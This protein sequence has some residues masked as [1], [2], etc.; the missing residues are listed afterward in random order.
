MSKVGFVRTERHPLYA[1]FSWFPAISAAFDD[2]NLVSCAG[3]ARTLSLAQR[4]GW[5]TWCRPR[6]PDG[7]G[8]GERAPEGPGTGRGMA[9]GA[10]RIDGMDLLR[11]GGISRLLTGIGAPSTLGTFLRT[12]TFGH[13]RQLDAVAARFLT[14]LAKNAPI[15]PGAD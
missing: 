2:P 3:L 11:Q 15:L 1:S 7:S 12:F 4:A 8:R 14:A 9:A 5:L 10:E 13:V 6:C